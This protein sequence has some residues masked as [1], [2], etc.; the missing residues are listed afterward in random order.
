MLSSGVLRGAGEP[1]GQEAGVDGAGH[2]QAGRG[3]PQQDTRHACCTGQ[4]KRDIGVKIQSNKFFDGKE[5]NFDNDVSIRFHSRNISV[6]GF[7]FHFN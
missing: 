5:G 2:P 1:R 3:H 6:T 4:S 7:G